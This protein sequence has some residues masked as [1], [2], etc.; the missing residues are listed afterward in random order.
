MRK[1]LKNSPVMSWERETPAFLAN[2][3]SPGPSA[4]WALL[5]ML[6]AETA[7]MVRRLKGSL[8]FLAARM[9]FCRAVSGMGVAESRKRA[10]I[11]MSG[12]QLILS[13]ARLEES[14]R[15]SERTPTILGRL[16][17]GTGIP[18]GAGGLTGGNPGWLLLRCPR[19]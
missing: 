15:H 11:G 2:P 5:P 8:T 13:S 14:G 4:V 19:P 16:A 12:W 17:G 18:P 6:I 1:V 9:N 10:K 3:L 7:P